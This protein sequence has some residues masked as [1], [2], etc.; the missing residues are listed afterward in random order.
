MDKYFVVLLFCLI[1]CVW[2]CNDPNYPIDCGDFCCV[3]N[4]T[5]CGQG[6]LSGGCCNATTA[7][8][9]VQLDNSSIQCCADKGTPYCNTCGY[10][11]CPSELNPT[12]PICCD[13]KNSTIC[14]P[15]TECGIDC[16][17]GNSCCGSRSDSCCSGVGFMFVTIT[18]LN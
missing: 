9:V 3:P 10:T 13:G 18:L 7:Q 14:C 12:S 4:S 8:C 15:Y 1:A 16:I 5:C 17:T 2:A 11:V 6:F